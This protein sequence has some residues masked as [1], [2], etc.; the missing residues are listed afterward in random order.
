M[1]LSPRAHTPRGGRRRCGAAARPRRAHRRARLAGG[2]AASAP[3]GC[4]SSR[5]CGGGSMRA[6]AACCCPARTSQHARAAPGACGRSTAA[7]LSSAPRPGACTAPHASAKAW[8]ACE[9]RPHRREARCRGTATGVVE[10]RQVGFFDGR[11]SAS[12]SKLELAFARRLCSLT[13]TAKA[14]PVPL[15]R[16]RRVMGQTSTPPRSGTQPRLRGRPG[17]RAH[18]RCSCSSPGVRQRRHAAHRGA[19]PAPTRG[20]CVRCFSAARSS[21]LVSRSKGAG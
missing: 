18:R 10:Q 13:A 16:G 17:P 15:W 6:A 2:S 19:P 8:R 11:C 12:P 5:R 7:S 14:R 20:G 1:R 9:C 21:H 3:A 4:R